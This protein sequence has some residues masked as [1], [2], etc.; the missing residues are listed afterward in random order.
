VS[1]DKE[2]FLLNVMGLLPYHVFSHVEIQKLVFLVQKRLDLNYF[3]FKA[4][5]YG[6]TDKEIYNVLEKMIKEGKALRWYDTDWR[7]IPSLQHFQ[8]SYKH[9]PNTDEFLNEKK[10]D[11]IK[12]LIL[13]VKETE[14][15]ELILSIFKEWPEM[16]VNCVFHGWRKS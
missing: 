7:G 10:R 16:S 6:P 13:F 8:V 5:I 4:D 11:L 12:K 9:I 1:E 3:D 2:K 15:R 14:F